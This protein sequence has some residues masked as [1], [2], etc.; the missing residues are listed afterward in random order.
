MVSQELRLGNYV[1]ST[2]PEIGII[3]IA[4]INTKYV[5]GVGIDFLKPIPLTEEWLKR[6][7]SLGNAISNDVDGVFMWINGEKLYIAHVHQLQ[8]LYF[9]LTGEEL[10]IKD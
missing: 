8:N 9:A 1:E 4:T 2:I 7:N 6:F 5:Q 3:K 10:T